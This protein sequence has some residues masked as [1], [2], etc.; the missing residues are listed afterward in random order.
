M[1]FL[2]VRLMVFSAYVLD[3]GPDF[4]IVNGNLVAIAAV[5]TLIK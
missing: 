5:F 4:R 3:Y 2:V 1:L